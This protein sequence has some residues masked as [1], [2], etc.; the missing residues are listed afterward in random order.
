MEEKRNWQKNFKE[1]DFE[2]NGVNP[3]FDIKFA[4]SDEAIRDFIKMVENLPLQMKVTISGH[5][6]DLNS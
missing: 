4:R 1:L 3:H 5:N 2:G 6:W